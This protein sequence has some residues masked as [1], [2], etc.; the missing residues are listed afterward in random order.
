MLFRSVPAYTLAVRELFPAR[1]A[2]WRIGVVFLFGTGGMALGGWLGGWL[3]DLMG[4]YQFAFFAGVI[5]NL[6]NLSIICYLIW[7]A[8]VKKPAYAEA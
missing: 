8:G 5:F 6:A 4:H 7:L 2:G 3:F 1:G